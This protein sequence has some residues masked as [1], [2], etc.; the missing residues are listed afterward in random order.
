MMLL[1]RSTGMVDAVCSTGIVAPFG[2][3]SPLPGLQSMKYSPI[4]DCGRDSQKTSSRSEPKPVWVISKSTRARW[5][6]RS[7]RMRLI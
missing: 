4:S 1:I 3:R 6:L 2:S 7:T 5:V